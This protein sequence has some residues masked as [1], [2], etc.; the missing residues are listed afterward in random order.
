[1]LNPLDLAAELPN[2]RKIYGSPNYSELFD[3]DYIPSLYFYVLKQN[4]K[5]P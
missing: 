2:V 3:F 5:K 4:I 1:M